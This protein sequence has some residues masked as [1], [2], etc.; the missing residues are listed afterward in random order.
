MPYACMRFHS[1]W[2]LQ[3]RLLQLRPFWL[4]EFKAEESFFQW[5]YYLYK[6]LCVYALEKQFIL[7]LTWDK[8]SLCYSAVT[9]EYLEIANLFWA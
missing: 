9:G 4:Q 8:A 7:S 1:P 3:R 5:D 6:A 2:L